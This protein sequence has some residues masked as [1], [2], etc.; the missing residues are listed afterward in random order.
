ME[1]KGQPKNMPFVLN[2]SQSIMEALGT[3]VSLQVAHI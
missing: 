3:L 2:K 1:A